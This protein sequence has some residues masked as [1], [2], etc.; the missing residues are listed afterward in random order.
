MKR[1]ESNSTDHLD[2]ASEK[3]SALMTDFSLI[4]GLLKDFSMGNLEF[5]DSQKTT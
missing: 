3:W 1:K 4:K 5:L 2:L